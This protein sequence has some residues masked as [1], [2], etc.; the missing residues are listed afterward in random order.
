MGCTSLIAQNVVTYFSFRVFFSYVCVKLSW[1]EKKK[2]L[3]KM[4]FL[5]FMLENSIFRIPFLHRFTQRKIWELVVASNPIFVRMVFFGP[6]QV[7]GV[8]GYLSGFGFLR[9]FS[10]WRTFF[11][12]EGTLDNP[13]ALDEEK[14]Q[15][16]HLLA[17]NQV[18]ARQVMEKSRMVA[19]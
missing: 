18:I 8:F 13:Q 15:R 14:K 5:S 10:F 11:S 3:F 12:D 9:T 16:E 7:F 19:G 4:K 2:K 6:Y 17:L 1:K